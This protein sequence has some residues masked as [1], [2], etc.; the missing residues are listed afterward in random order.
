MH[1]KD[2]PSLEDIFMEL[3]ERLSQRSK[4]PKIQVGCVICDERLERVI[5][6]G[7]NGGARGQ[8]DGRE[9]MEQGKSGLIHAE[10][11]ALVKCDYSIPN[12]IVFLTHSPCTVC[13]KMLV[14]AGVKKLYFKNKYDEKPLNIL[15][16]AGIYVE[17]KS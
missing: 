10:A 6:I 17:H 11:N 3:A 9:S 15:R 7:Y 12:K 14:N 1:V 8:D 4:D 2:R 5:A 13:A 16:T